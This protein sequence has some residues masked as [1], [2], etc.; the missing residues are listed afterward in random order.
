MYN[1]VNKQREKLERIEKLNR[2]GG[3]VLDNM[4]HTLENAATDILMRYSANK[5][6]KSVAKYFAAK[7][8]R[9]A[10]ILD[11]AA[12]AVSDNEN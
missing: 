10:K 3:E 9:A 6:E 2:E 11:E 12:K 4:R 5:T 1:P 8:N 7:L